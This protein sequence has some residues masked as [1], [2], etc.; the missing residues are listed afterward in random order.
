MAFTETYLNYDLASGANDGT[1]E[2]DAWQT[3]GDAISGAAAGDRINVKRT[4]SRVS[5]GDVQW[6]VSGTAT[7]PIHIRAY[8]TTIGDGGMF[9]QNN[10]FRCSGENVL[11]EGIDILSATTLLLWITG[12]MCCAYRCRAE[13]TGAGNAIARAQDASFINCYVKGVDIAASYLV[14]GQRASFIGCYFEL[15]SSD[16]DAGGS[17]LELYEY[18]RNNQVLNCI[19]KGNG[20]ADLIG[21]KLKDDRNRQ[22][23]VVCNNTIENC[24]IG[25]QMTD[26][27]ATGRV[28]VIIIQDNIIYNGVKGMENLQGTNTSTIGHIINNNAI[29]NLTGT[30]YTNMGD[31]V[32]NQITLTANPFIDTTD[33]ELNDAAGGGALCKFL[34]ASPSQLTPSLKGPTFAYDRATGRTN[35]TSIGGV[36]PKGAE[37]SH[38]F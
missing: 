32:L 20:D 1:S 37:S 38:V 33:Y 7:A 16:I 15:A 23:G 28:D 35:F 17:I 2:A 3:W 8:E 22:G 26:G 18:N 27:S 34:G 4:S 24:G 9:E 31:W 12:D 13:I 36:Q 5:S 25:L 19:I 11:I 29:G 14:Q 10:R 21:I 30:A 6:T